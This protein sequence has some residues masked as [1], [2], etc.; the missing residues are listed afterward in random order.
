MEKTNNS[1]KKKLDKARLRVAEIKG[2]YIHLIVYFIINTTLLIIKIVG[3]SYY[4]ET[5]MGPIWHFSTFAAWILWG[6]GLALHGVV[7]FSKNPFIGKRWEQRQIEKFIEE[8]KRKAKN[9]TDF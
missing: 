5:F 8:E 7:T 4:G 9:F 1:E 2:F 6:I 3:T